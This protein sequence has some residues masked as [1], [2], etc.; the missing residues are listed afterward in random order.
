MNSLKYIFYFLLG[1][2]IYKIINYKVEGFSNYSFI[3]LSRI[4]GLDNLNDPKSVRTQY[5]GCQNYECNNE[6]D[7]TDN[8]VDK[9]FNNDL[10]YLT[11]N[12]E[13]HYSVASLLGQ[14]C[15]HKICC[16]NK[17]C[18]SD[19]VKLDKTCPENT[20]PLE[21]ASCHDIHCTNFDTYCCSTSLNIVDEKIKTLFNNIIK[22]KKTLSGDTDTDTDTDEKINVIHFRN[23][24]YKNILDLESIENN[25][26]DLI[27]ETTTDYENLNTWIQASETKIDD[28][29]LLNKNNIT[30]DMFKYNWYEHNNDNIITKGQIWDILNKNVPLDSVISVSNN[31]KLV[32]DL[33]KPINGFNETPLDRLFL[34][35]HKN[36]EKVFFDIYEFNN[37][38]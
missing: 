27:F 9:E 38:L 25:V 2:I 30:E 20:I 12:N 15:N 16:F 21:N 31:K 6:I 35:K 23:F 28:I 8:Y 1:F 4:I 11:C 37:I 24:I 10:D 5:S 29:I 13:Q 18:S 36:R 22:L 14:R 19:D 33:D 26:E 17:K 32:I 34:I 7:T 3:L